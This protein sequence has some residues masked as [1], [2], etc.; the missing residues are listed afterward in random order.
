V[1]AGTV[2]RPGPWLR[3][4]TISLAPVLDAVLPVPASE[5][6]GAGPAAVLDRR[7]G[8]L[9]PDEAG[10]V[11]LPVICH[12][13]RTGR[14][15]VVVDSG[16]GSRRWQGWP[17]GRLDAVL[18]AIDV[19]P[20]E[21]GLVVT[22]H[23]HA[24]HVGWHTVADDGQSVPFFPRATYAIPRLEWDHWIASGSHLADPANRYLHDCITPLR[25]R[26]E[27]RLTDEHEALA[28][29]ITSFPTPGHTPGHTSVA[30][31]SGGDLAIIAGDA[32]HFPGQLRDRTWSPTWD[33]D[34]SAAAI[35]RRR[36]FAR[37]ADEP[38]ARLLTSHWPYPGVVRLARDGDGFRES[39]PAP[40]GSRR[41]PAAS[42]PGDPG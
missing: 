12:V 15:T 9:M 25:D 30:V 38:G 21:V 39:D 5:A 1:S 6:V 4:G 7:L 33:L 8:E 31:T 28:P 11:H 2:G 17:T 22:T 20:S 32:T 23:L 19:D 41:G 3:V 37:I 10:L 14:E 13:L 35:S 16:L 36:L 42:P 40:D 34:P 18:R 24:D 26:V 27:I 29:G